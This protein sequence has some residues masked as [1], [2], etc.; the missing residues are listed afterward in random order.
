MAPEIMFRPE[1]VD[2]E[3][4]GISENIFNCIQV[5]L[6]RVALLMFCNHACAN[7]CSGRSGSHHTL[8]ADCKQHTGKVIYS[9]I[10]SV[11]C[12]GRT[13][14]ARHD[15]M[16]VQSLKL[17]FEMFIALQEMDVDNRMTLYHH[18]VLSGGSTMYPGMPS[19]LERDIKAL[20]L[21]KVL[22]VR[23]L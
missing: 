15:T 8:L 5:G 16:H 12:S 10:L 23:M 7:M 21:D 6:D 17:A 18:I 2:V 20:Y 11:R 3:A 9:L 14:D 4:P 1:L 22:E 13:S 19:R